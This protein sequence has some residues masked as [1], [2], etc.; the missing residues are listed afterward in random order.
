MGLLEAGLSTAQLAWIALGLI[1]RDD[2]L[3]DSAPG[4]FPER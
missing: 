1:D 2:R 4:S 3:T